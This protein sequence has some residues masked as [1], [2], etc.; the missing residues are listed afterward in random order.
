AD[1]SRGARATRDGGSS[2]AVGALP[3][4]R[5]AGPGRAAATGAAGPEP[6]RSASRRTMATITS[7]AAAATTRI[8]V[9]ALISQ[10]VEPCAVVPQ[11]LPLRRGGERELQELLHRMW[12][13]RIRVRVV[14]RE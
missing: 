6:P 4:R 12:V 7:A 8:R 3:D 13:L 5:G 10:S 1:G 11:D 14:R 9:V 2:A